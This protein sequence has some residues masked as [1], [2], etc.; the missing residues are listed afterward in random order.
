MLSNASHGMTKMAGIN[1]FPAR[2]SVA[3]IDNLHDSPAWKRMTCRGGIY[4]ALAT[5]LPVFV[6]VIWAL[7]GRDKSR[8][9]KIEAL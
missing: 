8:P 1:T 6:G 5:I 4:H 9:Y 7:F 2:Y 3:R